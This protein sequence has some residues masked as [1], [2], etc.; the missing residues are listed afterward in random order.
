[1]LAASA[2]TT[3]PMT[4]VTAYDEA[5]IAP[6]T[7]ISTRPAARDSTRGAQANPNTSRV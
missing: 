2:N 4:A 5:P 3:M 7:M 1:M 6:S